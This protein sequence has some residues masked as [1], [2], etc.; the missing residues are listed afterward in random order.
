MT[1]TFTG[2]VRIPGSIENGLPSTITL[3]PQT[4][5]LT[6]GGTE[7]GRWNRSDL[8][9]AREPDGAFRLTLGREVVL[10][11]PDSPL[12]FAI[13]SGMPGTATAPAQAMPTAA[14]PPAAFPPAPA[15]APVAAPPPAA[16]P[17]P[18][19]PPPMASPAA[20]PATPP[21]TPV[22][23]APAP[24]PAAPAPAPTP[25][26]TAPAAAPAA[27]SAP[28]P[29]APPVAAPPPAPAPMPSPSMPPPSAMTPPPAAPSPPAMADPT[30]TPAESAGLPPAPPAAAAATAAAA[31]V[32]AAPPA[33]PP[34]IR[35]E[36]DLPEPPSAPPEP[37]AAAGAP[38]TTPDTPRQAPQLSG[39]FWDGFHAEEREAGLE[40]ALPDLAEEATAPA[41]TGSTHFRL[42]EPDDDE[43]A[44]RVGG[45]GS[46]LFTEEDDAAQTYPPAFGG[47]GEAQEDRG[48]SFYEDEGT[49]EDRGWSYDD[50]EPVRRDEQDEE[51]APAFRSPAADR[52]ELVEK[53][54]RMKDIT[55]WR[56]SMPSFTLG[57]SSLGMRAR[58]ALEVLDAILEENG[59]ED[60]P[61]SFIVGLVAL[62]GI[63]AL[64]ALV[65]VI[66]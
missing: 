54:S 43:G 58:E 62:V 36:T 31:S 4:V 63:L 26:P 33:P 23:A 18:V 47:S 35:L 6:A 56:P 59:T 40:S 64:L 61:R 10:F 38:T 24:A 27:A 11:N 37:P 42:E 17:P 34:Q 28:P 19:A 48:W 46:G 45:W 52:E 25:A 44:Q 8:N 30:P 16:T 22:P 60:I 14:P 49:G 3:D 51:D 57:G 66:F 12:E 21:A 32:P 5:I 29:V 1:T 55:S 15:P 9:V 41:D 53:S 39:D 13:L 2:M 50:P 20:E 65:A 7:L